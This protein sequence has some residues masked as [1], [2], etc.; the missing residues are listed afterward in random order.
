[1]LAGGY[2]PSPSGNREG[3]VNS[4]APVRTTPSP[5]IVPSAILASSLG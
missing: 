3:A 2:L 1:M 5:A 4:N